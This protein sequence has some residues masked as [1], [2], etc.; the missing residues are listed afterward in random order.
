MMIRSER[1]RG[2]R[3]GS[4]SLMTVVAVLVAGVGLGMLSGS[5]SKRDRFV[6]PLGAQSLVLSS[7]QII[8]FENTVARFDTTTGEIAVLRGNLDNPSTQKTWQVRVRSV[9]GKT[10]GLL[11]MQQASGATF[12]VDI[13]DGRTWLLNRR[14]TNASWDEIRTI[15]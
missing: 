13:V 3:T 9:S 7:V 10:S 11:E 6:R 5:G 4:A 2:R 14:S 1:R 12:L 8:A 15:R